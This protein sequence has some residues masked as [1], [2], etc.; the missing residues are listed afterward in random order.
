MN[1][2]ITSDCCNVL[3]LS[4][5]IDTLNIGPFVR[6]I[7]SMSIRMPKLTLKLAE[8]FRNPLNCVTV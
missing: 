4:F 8:L 2:T 7:H 5:N 3:R 6:F 1:N